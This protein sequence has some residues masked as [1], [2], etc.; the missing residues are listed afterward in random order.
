MVCIP[1]FFVVKI[2]EFHGSLADL[3]R[4]VANIHTSSHRFH[5]D[6]SKALVEISE[7]KQE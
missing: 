1:D 4:Y 2:D 7:K 6:S 3:F 5:V